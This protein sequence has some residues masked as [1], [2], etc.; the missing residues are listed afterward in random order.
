MEVNIG[1]EL[2]AKLAR[3]AT[4]QGRDTQALVQEAIEK[5]VDY[6]EW[7]LREVE[8][9]LAAADRGELIDHEDVGKL[10]NLRYPG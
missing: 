2:E 8:N 3:L 5:F 7:F 4:E 10:I 1:P 9:G 6:D